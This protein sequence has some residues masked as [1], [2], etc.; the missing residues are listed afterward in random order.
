MEA[1]RPAPR[2][3]GAAQASIPTAFTPVSYSYGLMAVA[4][5]IA[6]E[7]SAREKPVAQRAELGF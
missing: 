1:K 7:L 6:A 2:E 4:I 3:P 5:G